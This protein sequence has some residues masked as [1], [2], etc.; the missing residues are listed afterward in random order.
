MTLRKLVDGVEVV[1]SPEEELAILAE[2]PAAQLSN[3]REYKI[4]QL[5]RECL[6][7]IASKIPALAS[8]SSISLMAT[9]WPMLNTSAAGP[10]LLACR[11]IFMYAKNKKVQLQV[12]TLEQ[13]QIY[14]TATD[15]NWPN[16]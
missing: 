4:S 12:A 8:A 5:D 7:R 1:C 14:E 3:L 16:V 13:L 11:D 6:K 15:P 2:R 10:E 9:L